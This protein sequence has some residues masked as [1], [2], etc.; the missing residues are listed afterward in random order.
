MAEFAGP[1]LVTVAYFI[2]WYYLLLIKQR[3]TKYRLQAEYRA[4]GKE[5]DRY[6][7]NDPQMLAADRA[8]VNTQEQMMPF[9][10]GLWLHAVFVSTSVATVLGVV[11]VL[12]RAGYPILLGSEVNRIQSKRVYMVTLPCYAI[13]FYLLG[14]TA[15]LAIN[16]LLQ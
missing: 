9:L 14:S 8:V 10:F 1:I 4:K 5:F 16:S 3:G 7:G 11:Y 13:V 2:F 6:F 15:W 12:L